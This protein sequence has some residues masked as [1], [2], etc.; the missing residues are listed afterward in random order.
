MQSLVRPRIAIVSAMAGDLSRLGLFS[1]TIRQTHCYAARHPNLDFILEVGSFDGLLPEG[2]P[3]HYIK[4]YILRKYLPHFDWVF[5]LDLDIV[6]TRMDLPLD[7]FVKGCS[8]GICVSPSSSIIVQDTRGGFFNNGAFF[9][10]NSS[11]GFSFLDLWINQLQN[12]CSPYQW[13]FFDQNAW[14]NTLVL[15]ANKTLFSSDSENYLASR[16]PYHN[17]CGELPQCSQAI[18]SCFDKSFNDMGL[19]YGNRTMPRHSDLFFWFM[20]PSTTSPYRSFGLFSI[21]LV[22]AVGEEGLCRQ[23]Q[24]ILCHVKPEQ[25][26]FQTTASKLPLKDS[27]YA[28]VEKISRP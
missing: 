12:H 27:C 17:E 22:E 18:E 25:S 24:D 9:I 7:P 4:P 11:Q 2:S 21:Y 10:R 16:I 13:K 1:Y 23:D 14:L 3:P 8:S 15:T 19:V 26:I 28:T 5:W 20:P 6:F